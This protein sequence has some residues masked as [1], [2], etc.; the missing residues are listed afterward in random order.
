IVNGATYHNIGKINFQKGDID[1][2]IEYY[3]KSLEIL[4]H[5]SKRKQ[6]IS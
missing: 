6:K 5:I 4:E 1:Q 3:E 2:A